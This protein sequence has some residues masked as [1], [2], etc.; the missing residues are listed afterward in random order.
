MCGRY[1]SATPPSDLAHLFGAEDTTGGDLEPDFNVA[2]TKPV[3]VVLERPS[4]EQPESV[5]RRL[6]VMRWGLV[7]SWAKDAGIGA[8]MINARV[9]TAASKPAF[10]KALAVRRCLLPADGY[11]E[12]QPRPGARKQPWFI[13]R[14][15]GAPMA[16][17]GL[18]EIWADPAAG[19]DAP[20][21][22]TAAVL[23]TPAADDVAEIHDRTPLIV[24][25]AAWDRWLSRDLTE[26][27]GLA[28][29]LVPTPAGTLAA[30]PVSTIV[31]D[32]RNNGSQL[33]D[34]PP[35]PAPEDAAREPEQLLLG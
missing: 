3:P 8:R 7:P 30:R 20:R 17:A 35:R 31:N 6:A 4:R 28:A 1:A 27:G 14:A 18:Y 22:W 12:W 34:P 16:L 21:L 33:L 29:L 15:D 9:E 32:V 24:E 25:P 5:T 2:P 10:R 11:Y 13:C 26:P 19:P 23:T